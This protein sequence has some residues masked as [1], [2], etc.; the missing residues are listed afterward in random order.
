[1]KVLYIITKANEIGGAQIHLRDISLQLKKDGHDVNVLVGENGMLVDK[2]LSEGINV[3]VIPT[4]V[5][6]ISPV[7]DMQAFFKVRTKIKKIAPDIIGLHSSKAGIIG[8]LAAFG[9]KIPVVFTAHGWAFANGVSEKSKKV[10]I[11]IEKFLSP[12]VSKI[13]TV[14]AQDKLLAIKYNVA[15]NEKQIV[16]HNGMPDIISSEEV[17]KDSEC[18]SI[19]SIARFSHQK[20]HDTLIRALA[21]IENINWKLNL[22]GKGPAMAQ[23]KAKVKSLN[24]SSKVSFLGERDDIAALLHASDVFVLSTNWEGLPLSIIEAMRASLPVIATDV[25]G[26]SEL[27]EDGVNGF[28]VDN[29]NVVQLKEALE[30]LLTNSQLRYELGQAA[31]V[32]YLEDFTF[33]KMYSSTLNVYLGLLNNSSKGIK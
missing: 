27:V 5:R 20:D 31:R 22:V 29:K 7:K 17:K 30:K 12:L 6:K 4:L 8:R 2:L 32:K 11:L 18:I 19:I 14:S 21:N 9:L 23:S 1:M 3:D 16:I 10:Y 25:G 26:V 24:L 28:L 15:S 33:D 13:I